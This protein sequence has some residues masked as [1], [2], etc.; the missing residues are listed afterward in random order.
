[1][2]DYCSDMNFIL[3]V[4]DSLDAGVENEI[5]D[6][7]PEYKEVLADFTYYDNVSAE[8]ITTVFEVPYL[9]GGEL[10]TGQENFDDYRDRAFMGSGL[11]NELKNRKF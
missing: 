4:M 1:M 8:Y 11:V 6:Q 3:L 10:Y 9:V 7:Y 2:L 5:L